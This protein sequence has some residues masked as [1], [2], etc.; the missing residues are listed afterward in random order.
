MKN[1]RTM[2][3][4]SWLF[5]IAMIFYGC[6]EDDQNPSNL[7]PVANAGADLQADFGDVVQIDGS[8]SSDPGGE[9]LQY[10]W[11]LVSSPTNSTATI[12][13]AT[14]A[15]TNITPDLTGQYQLTLTVTNP[16]GL[17]AT[18]QM[19]LTVT[20]SQETVII[21]SSINA[22]RVL[23]NIFDNPS[24]PDYR[25]TA[26][27]NVTAALEIEPGV[28]IEFEDN[29]GMSVENG[30]TINAEGT[31]N[32]NIV[33]T[34]V[35]KV[36][37]FW[38]GLNI[39]TSSLSNIFNHTVV[40]FGGSAGFDGAGL[41]A[42][43]ML[44][45]AGRIAMDNSILRGSGGS[46]IY[47]RNG[48]VELESFG[49]NTL[50][51]NNYP[52][53]VLIS[54]FHL[55]ASNNEY[56]GNT[57]DFINGIDNTLQ[58]D[59]TW[60]SLDV[61][62]ML[63]GSYI[64]INSELTIAAGARFI[65]AANAGLQIDEGGSL[66]AIGTE[67][68]NISFYGAE[69]VR[70]FWRGISIETNN[71]SNEL[72]Y[73]NISNGGSAGFDGG[74]VKGNLIVDHSG[75]LKMNNTT[76][77]KSGAAG[78][79]VRLGTATLSEF[80]NNTITDNAFSINCLINHFAFFDEASN[81][82]GNDVDYVTAFGSGNVT[83]NQTWRKL[84]VPYRLNTRAESITGN[85]TINPGVVVVGQE[86]SGLEV[87]TGGSMS[88]IGTSDERIVF[89]GAENIKGYWRGLRFRT[90]TNSNILEFVNISNGG[91]SGFDGGNRKANVEVGGSNAKCQFIECNITESG[92]YGIR[93]QSGG[94]YSLSS[95]NFSGNQLSG[96]A[97]GGG[98]QNDNN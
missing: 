67:E 29:A 64:N 69:D 74:N 39:E 63:P 11:E 24:I 87:E 30:G 75:R 48:D 23:E 51:E 10:Q 94:T 18:D 8:A 71:T 16:A 60:Q 62:Y 26:N 93:I 3:K 6:G 70:A 54:K 58:Q 22:P 28:L 17:S 36:P 89:R 86:N 2:T 46:G 91:S 31:A 9:P 43:I 19:T 27:I 95:T 5:I 61:P 81:Y 7:A 96:N 90:N 97:N 55:L 12:N 14:S 45:Q 66:I 40:E 57:N 34:G 56:D 41:L 78:L 50:T 82:T 1:L 13:S 42:N 98:V 49:N 47:L 20:Q 80:A 88:A 35:Q 77:T 32:Q 73:V 52:A 44:D 53:S 21:S 84:N 83:T 33:F 76:L 65:A 4:F 38:R 25:V 79:T 59:V 92:G 72:T 37:G 85:L 68:D 15:I